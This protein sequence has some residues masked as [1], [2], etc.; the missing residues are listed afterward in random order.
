MYACVGSGR[1][2]ARAAEQAS[3]FRRIKHVSVSQPTNL[4]TDV[5]AC[6]PSCTYAHEDVIPESRE[7]GNR[8]AEGK[9]VRTC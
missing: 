9:D 2:R 1:G 7:R 8:Q 5:P 4:R 3:A 6:L